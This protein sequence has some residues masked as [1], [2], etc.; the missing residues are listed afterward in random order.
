M[1]GISHTL[2]ALF[3][4][5]LLHISGDSFS[6]YKEK[7]YGNT[8]D[9]IV[10]YANFQNAYKKHFME[11]WPFRGAGREKA[12]PIGLKTVRIGLLAPLED[13]KD[14]PKG[15]QMLNGAILAMEQANE[16]GGYKGIPFELMAHNDVGLWGAAANEVVSMDD[17]GCWA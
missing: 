2:L 8:P 4:L 17:E 12:E 13:S 15:K 10:P 9:E 16:R 3:I 5:G 11:P 6:Q 7:N 14:M 1:K